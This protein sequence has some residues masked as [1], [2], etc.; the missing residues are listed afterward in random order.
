MNVVKYKMKYTGEI[1]NAKNFEALRTILK[2]KLDDDYYIRK[3]ITGIG[4]E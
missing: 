4:L 2:T 3:L 1:I